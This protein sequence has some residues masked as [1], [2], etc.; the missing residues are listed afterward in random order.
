MGFSGAEPGLKAFAETG[1]FRAEGKFKMNFSASFSS[2]ISILSYLGDFICTIEKPVFF[3]CQMHEAGHFIS[4]LYSGRMMLSFDDFVH[5]RAVNSTV[6][7]HG[8]YL[9]VFFLYIFT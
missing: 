9:D 7:Y 6:F 3:R 1:T 2:K 4:D 5:G 8:S